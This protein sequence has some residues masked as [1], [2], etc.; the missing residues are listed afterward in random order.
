MPKIIDLRENRLT[1]SRSQA[2]DSSKKTKKIRVNPRFDDRRPPRKSTSID[3]IEWTAPEFIRYKKSKRWFVLPVIVALVIIII[4]IFNKN[5]LLAIATVLAAFVV[6]I[7]AIKEPRQII[8]SISG[9]GIQVGKNRHKFEDLKS[10]WIFYDP[11]EVKE[12]SIRSRKMFIPYIKIPLDNQD[13]AK[14]RKLLLNFLPERRHPNLLT[15][16]VARKVKF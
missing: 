8:F 4:A 12:L 9:R 14:I 5:F 7:Y 6:C 2:D 16:E 1:A 10:F 13:P 11:P 3:K 15:D